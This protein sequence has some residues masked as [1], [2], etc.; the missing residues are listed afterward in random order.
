MV[1]RVVTALTNIAIWRKIVAYPL[2][3]MLIMLI[4]TVVLELTLM[5]TI[6]N[7]LWRNQSP[8]ATWILAAVAFFSMALMVITICI[9]E[10]KLMV[11][12]EWTL[13]LRPKQ[14]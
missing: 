11:I 7:T 14:L 3:V 6:Q 12:P 5:E 10:L 13:G 1:E 4:R 2:L 8:D 9:K